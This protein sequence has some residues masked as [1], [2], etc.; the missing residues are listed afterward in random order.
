MRRRQGRTAGQREVRVLRTVHRQRRPP[1]DLCAKRLGVGVAQTGAHHEDGLRRRVERLQSGDHLGHGARLAAL[2]L[3]HRTVGGLYD[4]QRGGLTLQENQR[5]AIAADGLA[6]RLRQRAGGVQ[7]GDQ[8]GVGDAVGSQFAAQP[9]RAGVIGP[10]HP[11]R[12]QTVAALR[13]AFPGAQD[14][15]DDLVDTGVDVKGVVVD[16]DPVGG[17]A[18]HQRHADGRRRHRHT[19]HDLHWPLHLARYEPPT[20]RFIV[21]SRDHVTARRG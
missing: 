14:R 7:F 19:E 8:H 11:G 10:G 12:D 16:S 17:S 15:R 6:D 3:H 20:T 13:G 4:G 18:L 5:G 1:G 9:G 2:D 21:K